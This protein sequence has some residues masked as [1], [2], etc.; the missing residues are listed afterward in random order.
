M[1]I[2]KMHTQDFNMRA[3]EEIGVLVLEDGGVE[4]LRECFQSHEVK[5][6]KGVKEFKCMKADEKTWR[7]KLADVCLSICL[8]T[9]ITC[10][11]V[12]LIHVFNQL[13]LRLL[14]AFRETEEGRYCPA[15]ETSL[16][17]AP[18]RVPKKPQ[19]CK[20]RAEGDI[21]VEAFTDTKENN[22][23]GEVP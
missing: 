8:E 3:M 4:A 22:A 9:K 7:R 13:E 20:D 1:K 23:Y 2:A 21:K 16:K 14:T 18:E 6:S 15:R 17:E 19:V 10:S 12:K 5:G 11:F